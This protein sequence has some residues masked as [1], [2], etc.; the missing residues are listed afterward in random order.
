MMLEV[1]LLDK[2]WEDKVLLQLRAWVLVDRWGQ[3]RLS[4]SEVEGDVAGAGQLL[5]LFT[6][7]SSEEV[8]GRK[9][10]G[11][12]RSKQR[13]MFEEVEINGFMEELSSEEGK[14]EF[15]GWV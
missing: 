10:A 11:R 6:V 1:F 9:V 5:L 15:N 12:V 14:T 4:R 3:V 2:A 8:L 7:L 13:G